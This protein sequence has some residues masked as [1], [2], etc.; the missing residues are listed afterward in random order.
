MQGFHST[1]SHERPTIEQLAA[2]LRQE[3]ALSVPSSVVAVQPRG[4][5]TPLFCVH[6][7]GGLVHSYVDLAK[8]LGNDQPLYA[9]PAAGLEDGQVPLTD[10]RGMAA[11]Y[12]EGLRSIQPA[13]PYRLA[14]L[15]LG[16]VIAYEMAQQLTAQGETVSLLALMDGAFA[17][18]QKTFASECLENELA[19]WEQQYILD[20]AEE[21]LH[22][23]RGGN[24]PVVLRRSDCALSRRRKSSRYRSGRCESRAVPPFSPGLWQQQSGQGLL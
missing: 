23:A 11:R 4:A 16:S 7:A 19:E 12:V 15:S 8:H 13:G 2:Y 1:I 6:P 20:Q 3:V 21:Q 14:G 17:Y 9:F 22:I 5:R 10:I 18:D 24:G